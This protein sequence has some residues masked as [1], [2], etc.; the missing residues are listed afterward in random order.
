[1]ASSEMVKL[2]YE[3]C[4][5]YVNRRKLAKSCKFFHCLLMGS[6]KEA[7]EEEIE[8]FL[9]S[10]IFSYETF[11]GAIDFAITGSLPDNKNL[12][13]YAGLVQL[14]HLWL[15]DELTTITEEKLLDFVK[16]ETLVNLHTMANLM[17][18]PKLIAACEAYEHNLGTWA[19][20]EPK[21]WPTCVFPLHNKRH[22][23]SRCNGFLE[24]QT[25][26]PE[27]ENWDE[28]NAP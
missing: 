9:D 12:A 18:L 16:N 6:F 28:P 25:P 21:K 10:E 26:R 2:I 13:F 3:D 5:I 15:Y 17:K 8:I 1:M 27:V 7:A 11:K 24:I 4:A 23:Y 19:G 20:S 22:H 14:A